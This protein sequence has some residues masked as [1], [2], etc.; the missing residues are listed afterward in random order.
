MAGETALVT[1][2]SS[3]IGLELTRLFAADGSNLILV[4]RRQEALET[5]AAELR[6]AHGIAVTVM[7]C[8]LSRPGAAKELFER[9]ERE[10]VQVDVLVN[11]AGFGKMKPFHQIPPDVHE[12]MLQLNVVALNQLT[13]LFVT[14]MIERGYGRIL[15]VASTASFQPGPNAA[16][17][18]ASKAYVRFL[19]EAIAEELRGT[20]VT[21]T[22]L[23]PGP[24]RT[25][26]GAIS[27]MEE[28]LLFKHAMD[29]KTVARRG[30]RGLRSG[31]TVVITGLGNKLLAFNSKLLP[32]WIVR[33]V[34][35]RL[36]PVEE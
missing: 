21:V 13:R 12:Q 10:G 22:C 9:V 6:S 14:G 27:A 36:Q 23:C 16:A 20:G 33:K 35:Q 8:D 32:S 17:Y 3:G 4:A 30:Y 2:A 31:R 29:A 15:N 1:G 34:V 7:S 19:S 11:N 25:E 26:F 5:L 28:T 24:T 18:Y